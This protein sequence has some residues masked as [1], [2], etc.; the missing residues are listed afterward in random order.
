MKLNLKYLL[1][2]DNSRSREGAW[3]EII[4]YICRS[5]CRSCR[6]REGAWI[7]IYNKYASESVRNSVAPARERGLKS[8]RVY[9]TPRH[10]GRSREGAW[11]EMP[12]ILDQGT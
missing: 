3:I 12:V 9:H 11:I 5:F 8:V 7:E 6:S 4:I 10:A 2:M 1:K